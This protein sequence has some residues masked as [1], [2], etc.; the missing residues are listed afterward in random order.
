MRFKRLSFIGGLLRVAQSKTA[1][2]AGATRAVK[3]FRRARVQ[4]A[5]VICSSPRVGHLQ[6]SRLVSRSSP[7]ANTT[8]VRQADKWLANVQRN[9]ELRVWG[10]WAVAPLVAKPCQ[11]LAQ[12]INNTLSM[13]KQN[14]HAQATRVGLRCR[15]YFLCFSGAT[16][17][18]VRCHSANASSAAE[19]KAARAAGVAGVAMGTSTSP[20]KSSSRVRARCG[21]LR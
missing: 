10:G 11:R 20:S 8:A 13:R 17:C 12:M 18:C 16:P 2:V 15:G 5:A 9:M 4:S 1:R 21:C 14:S 6:G 7:T 19:G 3:R